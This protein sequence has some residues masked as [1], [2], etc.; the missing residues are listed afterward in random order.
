[1]LNLIYLIISLAVTVSGKIPC[2]M[3]NGLVGCHSKVI[4]GMN[5][6]CD[7]E[8]KDTMVPDTANLDPRYLVLANFN[9]A[10]L[11]KFNFTLVFNI[12]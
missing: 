4:S 8:G 2:Q 3:T 5:M 12:L 1:M 11:Q 9:F 10:R 7:G 6:Y